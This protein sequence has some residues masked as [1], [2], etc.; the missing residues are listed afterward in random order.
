[1]DVSKELKEMRKIANKIVKKTSLK[2]LRKIHDKEEKLEAI[3]YLI[4]TSLDL[5]YYDLAEKIKKLKQKKRDVFFAE[6]KIN[7]LGVKIKLFN[8]TLHQKDFKNI[9]ALFN[10]MKKE[11]KQNA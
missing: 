9:L 8:T 5:K 3:K 4:K 11:M 10:D 6:T 1:M 2:K 7:L